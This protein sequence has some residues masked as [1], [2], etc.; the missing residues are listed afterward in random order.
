VEGLKQNM[1]FN[2]L[3][4]V[5]FLIFVL[6]Q[7]VNVSRSVLRGGQYEVRER[8]PVAMQIFRKSIGIVW[9]GVILI[10]TIRP[11]WISWASFSLPIWIRWIAF[12]IWAMAMALLW[13]VELSLGRNFNTTLHLREEHTLVTEGPYR[14]VRHPMYAA[15]IPL[16]LAWLPASAN[17]LV[18]LPGL[19]GGLVI[20]ALRIP[21]E[22][23]VMLERFGDEYRAYM[24][25]TDRLLP[26]WWKQPPRS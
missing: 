4:G 9:F 5:M 2:I 17:W 10:Y 14:Y 13:W 7:F 11:E 19:I 21:E 1:R 25:Q 6:G 22:E 15:Q 8:N 18:G 26:R 12:G 20:F 23:K 16:I 3:F 24:D